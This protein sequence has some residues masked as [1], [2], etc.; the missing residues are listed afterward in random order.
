MKTLKEES[1]KRRAERHAGKVADFLEM[2][3]EHNY[4]CDH[5]EEEKQQKEEEKEKE[6]EK[7]KGEE[8]EKEKEKGEEK[9]KEKEEKKRE[10]I[11]PSSSWSRAKLYFRDEDR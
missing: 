8:K 1:E 10:K 4:K 6:G 2:L 7:E 5:P 11:T 9:E 3:R